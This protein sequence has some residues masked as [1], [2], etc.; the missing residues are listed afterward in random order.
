M[1]LINALQE[2]NPDALLFS[3]RDVCDCAVVGI[4]T[5]P[6]DHW[7]RET[8]CPAVAVYDYD[9]LL[10]AL[11]SQ[12]GDEVDEGDAYLMAVEW[13]EYNMIGAYVGEATPVVTRKSDS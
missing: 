6:E 13:M 8:P 5:M 2:L 7:P 3:P 4:T 11:V 12:A 10:D 1:S 9:L